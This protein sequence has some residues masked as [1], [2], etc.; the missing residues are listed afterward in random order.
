MA[1]PPLL[2]AK[3]ATAATVD[4]H[5]SKLPLSCRRCFCSSA[6]AGQH[7]HGTGAK[8]RAVVFLNASAHK[9][10]PEPFLS[11]LDAL[12]T[13][14]HITLHI[15]LRKASRVLE[16]GRG[17]K[18]QP[19][20]RSQCSYFLPLPFPFPP[21]LPPGGNNALVESSLLLLGP[22]CC[23]MTM[24]WGMGRLC[25]GCSSAIL[26]IRVLPVRGRG[27]QEVDC[28]ERDDGDAK[29]GRED[30][31]GEERENAELDP[32]LNVSACTHGQGL[33]GSLGCHR[34]SSA[35]PLTDLG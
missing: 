6:S 20:S 28:C 22:A 29:V 2:T 9:P 1:I 7:Q 8:V 34:P 11:I 5:P 32:Q 12:C 25:L 3:P 17:R 13:L 33:P 10:Q 35:A 30:T 14:M 24:P 27:R 15:I 31:R 4:H 21:L 18:K 26:I 23:M 19:G 16:K